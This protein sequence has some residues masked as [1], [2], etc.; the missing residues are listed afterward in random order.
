M[1][2]PLTELSEA[3]LLQKL[4]LEAKG[5]VGFCYP[6]LVAE[7]DRRSRNSQ[8]RWSFILSAVGLALAVV[9][10]FVTAIKA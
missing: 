8:A 6:D 4:R 10:L 7:L 9:A 2:E 1:S 5:V 3:E